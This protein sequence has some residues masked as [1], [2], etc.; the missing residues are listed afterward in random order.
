MESRENAAERKALAMISS[1][2]QTQMGMESQGLFCHLLMEHDL[3]EYS[4]SDRENF[5]V[6][7]K[8]AYTCRLREHM[9]GRAIFT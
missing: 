9:C 4:G 5:R 1:P 8:D 2:G 6:E 7:E 3:F